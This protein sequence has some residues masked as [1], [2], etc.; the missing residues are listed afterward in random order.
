MLEYLQSTAR[1]SR[2]GEYHWAEPVVF[3][4]HSRSDDD[5]PWQNMGR[6]MRHYKAKRC[7][8][9][10][11]EKGKNPKMCVCMC[12]VQSSQSYDFPSLPTYMSFANNKMCVCVS[13]LQMPCRL[14]N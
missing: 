7:F 14:A 2:S 4:D 8:C 9:T 11:F 10:C 3:V 12:L 1:T 6:S 5:K 13:M